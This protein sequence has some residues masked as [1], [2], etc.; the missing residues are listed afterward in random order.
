MGGYIKGNQATYDKQRAIDMP[1]LIR[2]IE[3]TQPKQWSRY[4][5]IYGDKAPDQ[6]Y[7]T[8]QYDVSKYGLIHVLRNGIKDRGV[9]IRFVYFAPASNL[10]EELVEKYHQNILT[11]TRQFVYST[12]NNNTIDMVLSVNGIPV[13]A[14]ELKNQFTGQTVAN[15]KHQFMYDCDPK[16]PIFQYNNR[17]LL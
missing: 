8:F 3:Q 9:G 13:V 17:V 2:F 12:E 16:E 4:Q 10:N 1:L 6:L 5:N 11:E 7:K 14:L 15:A